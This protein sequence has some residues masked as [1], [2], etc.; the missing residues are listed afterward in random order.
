MV[1]GYPIEHD[2]GVHSTSRFE[3]LY[4]I[5]PAVLYTSVANDGSGNA[6]FTLSDA[7]LMEVGEGCHANNT[8]GPNYAPLSGFITAVDFGAN[9]VTTT[10]PFLGDGD[11][12]FQ[13]LNNIKYPD[14]PHKLFR[15]IIIELK[16]LEDFEL[17]WQIT[18]DGVTWVDINNGKALIGLSMLTFFIQFSDQFNIRFTSSPGQT[19]DTE[20]IVAS[21]R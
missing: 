7:S 15:E 4:H 19:V 10:I 13:E 2:N 5:D 17:V 12:S 8:T 3:P 9:K 11:G 6:I 16:N 1:S 18:F 20:A 21:P 14:T